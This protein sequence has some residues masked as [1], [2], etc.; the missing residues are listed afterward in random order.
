MLI[1]LQTRH[2]RLKQYQKAHYQLGALQKVCLIAMKNHRA[3]T[4]TAS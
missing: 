3:E 1:I 4:Q 2:R